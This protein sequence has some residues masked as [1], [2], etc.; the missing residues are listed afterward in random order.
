MCCTNFDLRSALGRNL[1]EKSSCL[2]GQLG[3]GQP[4]AAAVAYRCMA[5]QP[6]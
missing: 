6:A 5:C 4:W 1:I 3:E 2:S